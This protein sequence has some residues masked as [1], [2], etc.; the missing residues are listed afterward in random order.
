MDAREDEIHRFTHNPIRRNK[1]KQLERDEYT[2]KYANR[3]AWSVLE[4]LPGQVR[5]RISAE[6]I[7]QNLLLVYFENVRL[8]D[9]T[10]E[11]KPWVHTV[12]R[13]AGVDEI[14]KAWDEVNRERDHQNTDAEVVVDKS[15]DGNLGYTIVDHR[16]PEIEWIAYHE[17]D[18][19]MENIVLFIEDVKILCSK[20]NVAFNQK[21]YEESFVKVL[22]K[23]LNKMSTQ[24]FRDLTYEMQ[25]KLARYGEALK[26][27]KLK[28]TSTGKIRA[29]GTTGVVRDCVKQGVIDFKEVYK[30]VQRQ[31]ISASTG[32]VRTILWDE[33]IK[34]GIAP[35]KIDNGVLA[36]MKILF[37]GGKGIVKV[38]EMAEALTAQ[39]NRPVY[40]TVEANLQELKRVYGLRDVG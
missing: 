38:K 8:Y 14:T 9:D 5:G 24:Q 18:E 4:K 2:I 31:G 35:K 28:I 10:R 11:F 23:T 22:D 27:N 29:A 1:M 20:F 30:E 32:S 33:R 26:E 16:T 13:N 12:I 34:A 36:R 21:K 17:E 7:A 3:K 19:R 15:E 39:G 25:M 37:N 6:D 40:T